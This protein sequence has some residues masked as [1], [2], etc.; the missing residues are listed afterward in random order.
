[1][2]DNKKFEY[3][4]SAKEQEEIKRIR[5]KYTTQEEHKESQMELLRKLDADV[6]KKG[7]IFALTLGIISTL[8]LGAGMSI[9]MT[10]IGEILRIENEFVIGLITGVIGLLGIILAFPLYKVV[11]KRERKRV[12]PQIIKI[13]DELLK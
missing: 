4:F 1:M 8:I 12:A 9:I 3:N 6:I 2:K 11:V 7:V 13:S 10:D 5:D